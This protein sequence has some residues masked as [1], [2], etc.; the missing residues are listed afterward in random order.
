MIT[1]A[2]PSITATMPPKMVATP[3]YLRVPLAKIPNASS[4]GSR[5]LRN[6]SIRSSKTAPS[7]ARKISTTT[8]SSTNEKM[9]EML[10]SSP[11]ARDAI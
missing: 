3:K 6:V 8:I 1:R 10:E 11:S 7:T 4:T 2:T 9:P 5:P